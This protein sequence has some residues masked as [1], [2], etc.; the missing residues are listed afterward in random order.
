M[1]GE[2][3]DGIFMQTDEMYY[4]CIKALPTKFCGGSFYYR[5]TGKL[6]STMFGLPST[7]TVIPL[8]ET[9]SSFY[10]ISDG[11]RF[12]ALCRSPSSLSILY[13]RSRIIDSFIVS[14]YGPP[15]ALRI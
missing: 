14:E 15:D 2:I 12:T 5:I 11:P 6:D 1:S 13:I 7:K 4:Y 9:I 3:E 8:A 10:I